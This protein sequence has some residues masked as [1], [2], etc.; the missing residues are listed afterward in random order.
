MKVNVYPK[1]CNLCGGRVIYTSNAKVYGREYGSG[2]C[3][4]CTECG[5]YV[6]THK[7][8]PKEALGLLANG[9]MRDL[10]IMCHDMFDSKWKGKEKAR[11][12]RNELYAWLAKQM[13]LPIEECHFGYFD[14]DLLKKAYAILYQI[15]DKKLEYD[16]HGNICNKVKMGKGDDE[17]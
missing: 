1:V 16:S 10:K 5:A 15:K 6:G 13:N 9:A 17:K 7:P 3:Y 4:F 8:R 14:E 11:K 2:K 12:K